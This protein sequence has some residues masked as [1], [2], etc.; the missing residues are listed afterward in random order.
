MVLLAQFGDLDAGRFE[1]G[2]AAIPRNLKGDDV[3][4]EHELGDARV[5][6]A[7][8]KQTF[9]AR[10]AGIAEPIMPVV[11]PG[12]FS[13]LMRLPKIRTVPP[14]PTPSAPFLTP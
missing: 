12:M 14:T 5:L 1:R 7:G 10:L 8:L 6:L 3:V 11:G 2:S 4:A 13:M 9:V